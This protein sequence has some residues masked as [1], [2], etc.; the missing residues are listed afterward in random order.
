MPSSEP[1]AVVEKLIA[2]LNRGDV[3]VMDEVFHDDAV[4][5]WPQFGERIRGAENRRHVYASIPKLPTITLRRVFGE[6]DLWVA[7]ASLDYG[8][9]AV[10][11]TVLIFEFREDRIARETA[12]WATPAAPADWRSEWVEPLG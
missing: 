6:G 10:F 8:E 3:S 7:E 12:Y 11:S 5:D 4:M 2:G 1:A 9:D